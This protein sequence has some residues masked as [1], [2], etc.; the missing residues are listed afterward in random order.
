MV[1]T[2][3]VG[4]HRM[5]YFVALRSTLLSVMR[6]SL[7]EHLKITFLFHGKDAVQPTVALEMN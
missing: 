2:S 4:R 3:A 7:C 1:V 5:K 6:N